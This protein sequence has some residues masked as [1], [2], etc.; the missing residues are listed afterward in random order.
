MNNEVKLRN[1]A[2]QQGQSE[3]ELISYLE[4]GTLNKHNTADNYGRQQTNSQSTLNEN[5]KNQKALRNVIVV[6]ILV[7]VW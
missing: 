1:K 2:Q 5:D 6:T 7:S 4:S 3:P